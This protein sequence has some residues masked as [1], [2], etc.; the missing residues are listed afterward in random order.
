L[1]LTTKF[2]NNYGANVC[3]MKSFLEIL[4]SQKMVMD[5][6]E[7]I[8]IYNVSLEFETLKGNKYK[9]HFYKPINIGNNSGFTSRN[10]IDAK[11]FCKDVFQYVPSWYREEDLLLG[12]PVHCLLSANDKEIRGIIYVI[13]NSGKSLDLNG[14]FPEV[15][16]LLQ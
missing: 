4:R 5:A 3:K 13:K 7:N 11:Y 12:I 10:I 2:S 8:L 15:K 1:L 14:F 16:L 9:I 6:P